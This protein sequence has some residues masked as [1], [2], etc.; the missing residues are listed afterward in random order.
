MT[1]AL[2]Q[3][4]GGP[5][6]VNLLRQAQ[7]RHPGDFWV[8][9][10]L[11]NLL[12]GVEPDRAEEEALGCYRVAL[13][14]RPGSFVVLNNLAELLRSTNRTAEA[15]LLCRRALLIWE[16]SLGPNHP[17][18]ATGPNNRVTGVSG[19]PMA[20]TLVLASMFIP[21]GWKMAEEYKRL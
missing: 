8:H 9:F 13:A 15:E 20:S 6:G 21:V 2:A 17:E 3:A 16:A 4:V 18:V 11:A 19:T 5:E 1:V 12:Q 14:L 10:T 7:E